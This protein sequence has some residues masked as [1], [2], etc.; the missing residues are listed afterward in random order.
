MK[1]D[2]CLMLAL[3]GF[4]FSVES[5]DGQQPQPPAPAQLTPPEKLGGKEDLRAIRLSMASARKAGD[6]QQR[7]S[8]LHETATLAAQSCEGRSLDDP[9]LTELV[10]IRAEIYLELKEPETANS[11]V[12]TLHEGIHKSKGL[13]LYE[14]WVL[15]QAQR[16]RNSAKCDLAAMH[17]SA[18]LARTGES[19]KAARHALLL[20]DVLEQKAHATGQYSDAAK[21]F[22]L[23][24]KLYGGTMPDLANDARLRQAKSLWRGGHTE[25]ARPVFAALSECSNAAIAEE[26]RHFPDLVTPGSRPFRDLRK[27]KRQP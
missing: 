8:R 20:G 12:A 5:A 1:S 18:L 4:A 14:T 15:L 11:I 13:D 19:P 27:G 17:L 10:S 26:A 3:L 22:A 24:A 7:R 21:Q 23:V 25:E 16:E 9:S 2:A 6:E